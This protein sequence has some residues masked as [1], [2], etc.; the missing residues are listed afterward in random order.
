MYFLIFWIELRFE[1]ILS[2]DNTDCIEDAIDCIDIIR[3]FCDIIFHHIQSEISNSLSD[4]LEISVLINC[5]FMHYLDILFKS[6]SVKFSPK[7]SFR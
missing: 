1:N 7:F 6:S 2:N 4:N 5:Y 3:N